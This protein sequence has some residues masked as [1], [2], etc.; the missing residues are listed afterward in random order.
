MGAQVG[1]LKSLF[2]LGGRSGTPVEQLQRLS[3]LLGLIRKKIVLVI[4]DVDRTGEDFDVGRIH[5]LLM[6]FREV[7]GISFIL[8]IS[9][10]Q[11]VDFAKL[12]DH[13]EIIPALE[14]GQVLRLVHQARE[15]MLREH[16]PGVLLSRLDALVAEDDDY[17][18][19]DQHLEYF[20]PWQLSLCAL[21]NR[22]RLLKHALR[23]SRDAWSR[24]CG[25]IHLDDVIAMAALRT[26]A[27]AAFGF[28]TEHYTLFEAA[29]KKPDSNI[30]ED[31]RLNHQKALHDEWARVCAKNDFDVRA[32]AGLLRQVYPSS[33]AVVGNT[34]AHTVIA[35]S[36]Q[37]KPRRNVYARRLF[38][39][40]CDGDE[41][42]DQKILGLLQRGKTDGTWRELAEIMTDSSFASLAF[43]HLARAQDFEA[44]LPLLTEIYAIMRLSHGVRADRDLCP[45]FI[46]PW[47]MVADNPPDEF[48]DWLPVELEKCVPGHLSLLTKIYY[49]WL[50][51]RHT[52]QQRERSRRATM[53]ALRKAWTTGTPESI[54]AGFDPTFPYVL[55]HLMFTTDFKTPDEVPLGRIA[56]W[57][58]S[59][60]LLLLAAEAKPDVMLPQLLIALN[61]H[62]ER[63]FELPQFKFDEA[64]IETLFGRDKERFY[65]LAAAG[66][67]LD[68]QFPEQT[69]YLLKLALDV[70][71]R[72]QGTDSK[73]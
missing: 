1:W 38:Q 35:Q 59:G 44:Y 41:V 5:A 26:G 2:T 4:E 37:S 57:K 67:G 58:W 39:E 8:A 60:P 20:W 71:R 70:A 18:V 7:P 27:P 45:G 42:S 23:R 68:S 64:A 17:Q 14:R 65:A 62:G 12:C 52:F 31:A 72:R 47:R 54:A 33:G 53:E 11:Q 63:P 50:G 15:L 49:Y 24:V 22:P 48:A 36:M 9:P 40:R 10:L 46:S 28:L 3:P 6:Q 19:F 21:L 30:R 51:D 73:R 56:D 25:E 69:R 13:L 32:A 16:P 34:M 66:F 29:A 43:E 61:G 55:F